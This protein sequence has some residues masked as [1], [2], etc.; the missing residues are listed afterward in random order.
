MPNNCHYLEENET[1]KL[2]NIFVYFSY[3][4]EEINTQNTFQ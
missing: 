3:T 1:I 2:G 4:H